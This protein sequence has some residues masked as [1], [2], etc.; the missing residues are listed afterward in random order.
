MQK[1]LVR[2]PRPS[3]CDEKEGG[4]G[5]VQS[6]TLP[7]AAGGWRGDGLSFPAAKEHER[8]GERPT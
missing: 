3:L 2:G 5:E 8:R 6:K 4:M 7:A 1:P